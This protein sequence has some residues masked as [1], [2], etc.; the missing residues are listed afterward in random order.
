MIKIRPLL[1]VSSAAMVLC[2]SALTALPAAAETA[3]VFVPSAVVNSDHTV[4][5]PLHHGLSSSGDVWFVVT[6]ASDSQHA[7]AW[8]SSVSQKLAHA[9]G[10]GAVQKVA[11]RA[12]GTLVFPRTV[13]FTPERVVRGGPLGFPPAVATPGAVAEPGYSPLVQ[14]PDGTVL[15]APQVANRSGRADKVVA[16]DQ[17]AHTVRYA[18]TDGFARGR[19]VVYVSTE[20]SDPGVAALEDVT[21]APALDRAP[22]AGGDGTDSARATLAAF[23][24]GATGA[25]NAQRQGLNSALQGEGDPLNVLAWTPNQGRYSPLWDVHLTAWAAGQRRLRQTSIADIADLAEEGAVSGFPSG[26]WRPSGF[27]VNCPII[28]QA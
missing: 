3:T 17:R 24:N 20:A 26:P 27:V 6:E 5:L 21:Y 13:D 12:D 28:A 22:F 14:L 23:T 10:T 18:L 16:I 9:R 1:A 15:N 11:V 8:R 7:K 19:A 25:R 2:T 4:T